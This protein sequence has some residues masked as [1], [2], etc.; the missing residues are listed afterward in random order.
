VL[1]A[2]NLIFLKLNIFVT[3][4]FHFYYFAAPGASFEAKDEPELSL[5]EQIERLEG[6]LKLLKASKF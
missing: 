5:Q 1:K 2:F 6:K 4:L 3:V